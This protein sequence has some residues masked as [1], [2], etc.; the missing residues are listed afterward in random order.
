MREGKPKY[1]E[2][3]EWVK[4]QIDTGK[5]KAGNKIPSEN[6]LS[7]Q[8]GL[9][10]Q[11]VRH[12][13]SV[14]ENDE[15]VYSLRGSGTYISKQADD[16]NN[17][18]NT[19]V[20]MMTFVDGYIFPRTIKGL[21][22]KLFGKGYSVQIAFTNNRIDRERIILEDILRKDNVAGIIAECTKSGLP[23]PDIGLYKQIMER[24][25]PLLFMNSF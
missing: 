22:D 7:N 5:L 17:N 15:I 4:Q 23:N 12:A 25:I 6:A 20:I 8:F 16:W 24:K 10:R 21:E 11:T 19:I 13:I 18:R 2:V 14:L 3:V 1:L 9:S